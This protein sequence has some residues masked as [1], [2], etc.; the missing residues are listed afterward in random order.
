MHSAVSRQAMTNFMVWP[1]LAVVFVAWPFISCFPI[2]AIIEHEKTFLYVTIQLLFL[3]TGFWTVAAVLAFTA[4]TLQDGARTDFRR[5]LSGKIGLLAV[6]A[7]VWTS[8]YMAV[9]AFAPI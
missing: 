8:L 6:Y 9:G 2:F 3:V 4:A 1:A 7:L 5:K